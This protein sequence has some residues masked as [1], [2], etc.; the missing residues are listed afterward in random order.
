MSPTNRDNFTFLIWM[1]FIFLSYFSVENIQ[2][3]LE[4]KW[5]D[6]HPCVIFDIWGR[7]GKCNFKLRS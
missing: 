1:P 4:L 3:N 2:Y 6:G 5:R 7:V